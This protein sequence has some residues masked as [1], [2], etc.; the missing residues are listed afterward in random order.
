MY[1]CIAVAVAAAV[2][3]AAAKGARGSWRYMLVA[4]NAEG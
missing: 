2:G 1:F 3:A 4:K